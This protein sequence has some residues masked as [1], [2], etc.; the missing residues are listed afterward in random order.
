MTMIP[1]RPCRGFDRGCRRTAH[2]SERR[3][4]PG[5]VASSTAREAR[6]GKGA[7]GNATPWGT[8]RRRYTAMPCTLGLPIISGRWPNVE[9]GKSEE[10][11]IA[12]AARRRDENAPRPSISLLKHSHMLVQKRI[13]HSRWVPSWRKDHSGRA[14]FSVLARLLIWS[15]P[16]SSTIQGQGMPSSPAIWSLA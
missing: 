16:M 15:S 6:A 4:P 1:M 11:A 14:R 7:Q 13:L 10:R 2:C 9:R 8:A 5:G 3:P 12:E